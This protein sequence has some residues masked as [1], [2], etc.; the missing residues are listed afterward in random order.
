VISRNGRDGLV[1]DYRKALE[2]VNRAAHTLEDAS[3][4]I[5]GAGVSFTRK[6]VVVRPDRPEAGRVMGGH[7]CSANF[8]LSPTRIATCNVCGTQ[9]HM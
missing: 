3:V 4:L 7:V 6:S 1:E 2:L 8:W 9:W 5:S